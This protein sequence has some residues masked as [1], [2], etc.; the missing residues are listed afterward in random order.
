V[1]NDNATKKTK[2]RGGI[3]KRGEK[4]YQISISLGKDTATGKYKY[5]SQTVRATREEA[6]AVRAKLI[7]QLTNGTFITP[8]KT[9]H[10]RNTWRGGCRSMHGLTWPLGLQKDTS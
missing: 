7:D 3:R 10:W 4:S 2:M 6:K 8:G 5:L 1:K 9:T